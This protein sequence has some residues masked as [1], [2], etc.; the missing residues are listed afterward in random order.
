MASFRVISWGSLPLGAL[1][2]GVLGQAFGLP[3]V[4]IG[5]AAIHAVLL[6]SR[7]VLTDAFMDQ[8]EAHAAANA[9]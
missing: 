4:F 7:L 3:A 2:G 5:A 8:V 6:L 9:G 1:L